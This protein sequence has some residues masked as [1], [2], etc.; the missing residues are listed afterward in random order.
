[1]T[2]AI[3]DS[4]TAENKSPLNKPIGL[5]M[6][7]FALVEAVVTFFLVMKPLFISPV[8]AK[9]AEY[10]AAGTSCIVKLFGSTFASE[11][12]IAAN[13]VILSLWDT[14]L[15]IVLIYIVITGLLVLLSVCYFKGFAFAKSYLIAIFGA[16]TIIG[17]VPILIPFYYFRNSMRIFG[18]IDAVICLAAC[19]YFVYES[20]MEYADD[21]LFTKDDIMDMCKRAKIGS[22]LFVGMTAVVICTHFA[23]PAYGSATLAGGNWSIIIGWLPPDDTGVAQGTVLAMLLSAALIGSIL[24]VR[25][26]DWAMVYYFSF[27]TAAAG[28]N[29]FAIIER[30]MWVSKTYNPIKACVKSGDVMAYTEHYAMRKHNPFAAAGLYDGDTISLDKATEWVGTNGMTSRWWTATVFLII[31][32]VAGAFV[33]FLA[34]TKIKSKLSFKIAESEKKPA[35]AVLIGV[36]ALVASFIFTLVAV[37]MYDKLL[38][39]SL[40]FGAMD[41]MYLMVYAG[42][43]VFLAVAMWSGYSFSKIGTLAL[44]IL[45]ASNNFSSIFTVFNSRSAYV[46][47]SVAAHNA[48][49]EQGLEYIPPI[50]KGTNYIISGVFYILSVIACLGI[51][52]VFV[53]KEVKDYMYQKRYS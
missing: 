52:A 47:G 31:A 33:A 2:S 4:S 1:M 37:L 39:G 40:Q 11:A 12:E 5:G 8:Y 20:S 21:M 25:E 3:A 48:A 26:G 36:G 38:F 34:F 49:I 27:G 23:M 51:I 30:F 42:L 18:A 45:I 46:A 41:Y 14:I 32:C 13:Q 7:V 15:N 6:M 28:V 9:A 50:L 29:I 35:I 17:L 43:T 10:N 24:Y 22:L 16:K 53:V 19:A 44:F